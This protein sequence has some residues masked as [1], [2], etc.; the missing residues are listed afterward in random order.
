MILRVPL[1]GKLKSYDPKTKIG[2]GDDNDVIRPL[3]FEKLLPDSVFRWD[4]LSCD[5]KGGMAII[6]ISFYKRKTVTEWDDSKD[7]PEEIAWRIEKD[8]ELYE[9]Q[10]DTERLLFNLFEKHTADELYKIT[11]E[12]KVKMP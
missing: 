8:S 7:P 11:G 4:L 3:A 2:I 6:E 1:T 5:Y 9:R 10:V 12:P